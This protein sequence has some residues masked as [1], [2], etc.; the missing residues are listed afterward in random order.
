MYEGALDGDFDGQDAW[1]TGWG[2]FRSVNRRFGKK[3]WPKI[4]S[5][6]M[7]QFHEFIFGNF[8]FSESKF[9]NF[10][11]KYLKTFVKLIYFIS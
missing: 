10:Y 2:K 7:N 9:F 8:P 11:G 3:S 1:A 5:N 4:S 6:E